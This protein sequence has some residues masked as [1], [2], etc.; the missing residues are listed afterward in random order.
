MSS[1]TE[2]SQTLEHIRCGN[3]L[4]RDRYIDVQ[5]VAVD[6][7][8]REEG[9]LLVEIK[10]KLE[11]MRSESMLV[12]MWRWCG[13][14]ALRGLHGVEWI[15]MFG[16]V[17]GMGR[18]PSITSPQRERKSTMVRRMENTERQSNWYSL[19]VKCYTVNH[20]K[21]HPAQLSIRLATP[22]VTTFIVANLIPI[23]SIHVVSHGSREDEVGVLVLRAAGSALV[24]KQEAAPELLAEDEGLACRQTLAS[25]AA[26]CSCRSPIGDLGKIRCNSGSVVCDVHGVEPIA[27]AAERGAKDVAVVAGV[28]N[29][30]AWNDIRGGS[31]GYCC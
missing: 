13:A 21:V 9:D 8:G 15:L 17:D 12:S 18:M 16:G 31:R 2:V 3:E 20:S 26:L 24:R 14:T 6:A 7:E 28:E 11:G 23:A 5:I 27:P 10:G 29:G 30:G 4:H 19:A 25:I 1:V 22:C